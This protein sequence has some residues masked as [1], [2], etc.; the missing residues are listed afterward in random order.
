MMEKPDESQQLKKKCNLYIFPII[1]YLYIVWDWSKYL[2]GICFVIG[3]Y[4]LIN[5]HLFVFIHYYISQVSV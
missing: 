3:Y 5:V 1:F 4:I 2:L